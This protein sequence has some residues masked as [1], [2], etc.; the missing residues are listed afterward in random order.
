MKKINLI[1]KLVYQDYLT[2]C[3]Y[4]LCQ[5]HR[6]SFLLFSL[7]RPSINCFYVGSI[8]CQRVLMFVNLRIASSS[9][10]LD[11]PL[12]NLVLSQILDGSE[13]NYLE[14]KYFVYD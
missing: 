3:F 11:L 14:S 10:A 12:F 5:S 1:V 6:Y 8:C 4:S 9:A 13:E 7:V 2:K